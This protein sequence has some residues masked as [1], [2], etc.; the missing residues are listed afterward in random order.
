MECA[1]EYE[2]IDWENNVCECGKSVGTIL[3]E[4]RYGCSWPVATGKQSLE[5]WEKSPI[6]EY[7]E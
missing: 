5:Q 7:E 6:L 2:K 3:A 1:H 4:A